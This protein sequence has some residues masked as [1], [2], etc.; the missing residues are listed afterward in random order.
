MYKRAFA[1]ELIRAGHDLEY[2]TRNRENAKYQV[3]F[4]NDSAKLRKDMAM[5]TGREYVERISDE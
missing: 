5:L 4:F 1:M 3:Y 2:T